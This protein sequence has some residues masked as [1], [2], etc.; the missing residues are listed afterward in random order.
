[1]AKKQRTITD[2]VR[3]LMVQLPE[4]EEFTSHGAPNFRVRG[5]VFAT[6]NINH[7]GDGR[8]ALN[9]AAQKGAQAALVRLRP[10]VYFVPPYVGP[11]GWLGVEL[12]KGLAWDEVCEH[13][14][15]AYS[16]VAPAELVRAAGQQKLSVRPPSRKFRPEEVDRFK[17]KPAIAVLKRLAA[18]CDRLPES[19]LAAV[20]GCPVWK[21]GKKTF[22]LAHYFTGRLK[23]SFWVG[24]ARQKQLARDPRF[25]I[26]RYTGHNGWIDLDV[27]SKADWKEIEPLVVESYRHFALKRMLKELDGRAVEGLASRAKGQN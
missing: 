20:F 21:A 7:H 22:V 23:L 13:V 11:Y 15:E 2:V 4:V 9:L 25:E 3:E 8:V 12:D 27:E 24:A 10:R 5:K 14:R 16:L 18:I 26:S 6:Y 19:S 1:M 17:S